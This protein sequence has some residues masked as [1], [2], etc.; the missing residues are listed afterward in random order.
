MTKSWLYQNI[1]SYFRFLAADTILWESIT[2]VKVHDAVQLAVTG[3]RH[4]SVCADFLFLIYG[5]EHDGAKW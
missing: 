2:S 3:W 5:A 4:L 1:E